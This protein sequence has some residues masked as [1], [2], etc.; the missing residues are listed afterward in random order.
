MSKV[1]KMFYELKDAKTGELLESNIDGQEI[2]FVSG[3]NQVLESL[4]A[5]VI[6]LK[7]GESTIISIP[8][9]QGVGEYDEAALQVLPKEQFA[10][11]ELNEGMELFGEGEDGSSVRVIVKAIGENEVTV[12]FNHPYAGKDLEF[13]VK[14][15]ENRD[16]D[17]DEE[18]TGVVAMPHVCGC[19]GHGH[20]HEHGGEG[21]CGGHGH[22]ED[23][24]DGECCG[25]HGHDK[26]GGGCCG[27]HNH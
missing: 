9:A 20:H 1:I 24:E 17:A 15:T 21:C 11:I 4:E 5:G 27:K 23:H 26:D 14:V 7:S 22:N 18:L 12:D 19:G 3:K 8:A 10:G 13:N 2:A 6:N 25:G 16:A